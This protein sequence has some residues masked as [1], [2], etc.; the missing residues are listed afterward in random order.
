MNNISLNGKRG[1]DRNLLGDL[2][3]IR[4]VMLIN[5]KTRATNFR[6]LLLFNV[7]KMNTFYC[8]SNRSVCV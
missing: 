8:F 2:V 5:I 4:I 3:F 7:I 1:E 6:S